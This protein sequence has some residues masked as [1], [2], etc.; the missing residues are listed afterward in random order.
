MAFEEVD[1]AGWCCFVV[2]DFGYFSLS[3][4]VVAVYLRKL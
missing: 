1:V 2:L 4:D 3:Q